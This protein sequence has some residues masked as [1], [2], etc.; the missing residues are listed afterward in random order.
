VNNFFKKPFDFSTNLDYIT[1]MKTNKKLDPN[2]TSHW[3]SFNELKRRQ[4]ILDAQEPTALFFVLIT[5]CMI[6]VGAGFAAILNL[7][8]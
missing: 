6:F 2:N 5:F 7:I 8:I 1:L 3:T 4:E